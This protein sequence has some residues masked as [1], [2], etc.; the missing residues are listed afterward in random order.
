[1]N[2]FYIGLWFENAKAPIRIG[3][4]FK[5]RNLTEKVNQWTVFFRFANRWLV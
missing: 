4:S 2:F 3:E 5:N 1:M